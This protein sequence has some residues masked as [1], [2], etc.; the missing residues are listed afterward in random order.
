MNI[1]L[2][3]VLAII[4][5]FFAYRFYAKYISKIFQIDA[6][7]KTP[8]VEINDGVDFVPTK[9]GVLFSHHFASIAGGGPILG[10]TIALIYGYQIS[11][12]WI[13]LGCVLFGAV[14]DFVALIISIR[15]KGKS[16]AEVAR[17]TLGDAGFFIFVGFT[18]ICLIM[19][20]VA[21]LGAT[22][23]ALTSTYPIEQ[24]GLGPDQTLLNTITENGIIKG[25]IGGIAS[26]SVFIITGFA[27]ILGYLLYIRKIP[28]IIASIIAVAVCFVSII[29]GVAFPV[30]MPPDI[31][32]IVLCFYIFISAG[33]PVWIVLQPRDFSNSFILYIGIIVI[34]VALLIGGA[35][36]LFGFGSAEALSVF[37]IGAPAFNFA[38]GGILLGAVWPI[39]FITI[40]CG[41]ISGFHA[42]VASGTSSKQISNETHAK[43]IGYGGMLLE[44][45][46]AIGVLSVVAAGINFSDY[47]EIVFPTTPGASSNPILAFALS[48]GSVIHQA[49]GI[50]QIYGTI[51]GILLVEGFVVTTLDTSVR[52]CRYLLEEIWNV[53]FKKV[54]KILKSYYFNAG[55]IVFIGYLLSLTNSITKIWPIFGS[56]NQLLAALVL[57][58]VAVW[59]FKKGKPTWFVT[60]PAL[61]MLVTSI[62]SLV[63]LLFVKYLPSG[64]V[65]L[66][67]ADIMLAVLSG[68]FIMLII[69]NFLYRRITKQVS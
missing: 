47:K 11:L 42:L 23:S 69:R 30:T 64:N 57:T 48:L 34:M 32:R 63:Y 35:A 55:L 38:E 62:S 56:A 13:I 58:V 18:V 68:A 49:F 7:K 2:P 29:I 10:P 31:W 20:I 27:P 37:H 19:I 45:L 14:H 66:I 40:A 21:F 28:I 1:A 41:A 22:V 26:T 5:F 16:I 15:E 53:S 8:S 39:L 65:P 17:K 52:L 33:I 44:G 59:L 50:N 25:K 4:V 9:P 12:F 51:F 54:P 43:K 46:F 6:A 61:F 67:V 24:L 36:S 60:L 3:L